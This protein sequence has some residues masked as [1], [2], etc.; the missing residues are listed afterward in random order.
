MCRTTFP[1]DFCSTVF[2]WLWMIIELG[3]S[4]MGFGHYFQLSPTL[5]FNC[6][7]CRE[8]KESQRPAWGQR[9]WWTAGSGASPMNGLFCPILHN[10]FS[11]ET[12]L[13]H[14]I[15]IS[16]FH[17]CGALKS[18]NPHPSHKSNCRV[19]YTN[20]VHFDFLGTIKAKNICSYVFWPTNYFPQKRQMR[21]CV[22]N[23][24]EFGE[25]RS[26]MNGVSSYNLRILW[27]GNGWHCLPQQD[28][29]TGPGCCCLWAKTISLLDQQKTFVSFGFQ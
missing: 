16:E 25:W 15:L 20:Q 13:L 28:L 23:R 18:P 10:P 24:N 3:L 6:T 22:I 26:Q 19:W 27:S 11:L 2:F 7:D 29:P 1:P 17:R 21:F 9:A 4:A 12:Q 5:E 8:W 14:L